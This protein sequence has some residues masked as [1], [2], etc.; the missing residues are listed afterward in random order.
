MKRIKKV[1]VY[2]SLIVLMLLL[3][4][5]FFVRT[6]KLSDVPM[7]GDEL[8][9]LLDAK[10]L[11]HTG[12]DQTGELLPVTFSMG[13]GRP[14][15]YVYATIP[16]VA[17]FGANE[18]GVRGLSLIS[19]I[20]LIGLLYL[21]GKKLF[22]PMVGLIAAGLMTFSFWDINLSRGGFEAHFALMLAVLGVLGILYAQKKP[23]WLII[24]AFCFGLTLHTYPTYKLVLPLFLTGLLILH[25][26]HVK[27]IFKR[28]KIHFLSSIMILAL[29]SVAALAQTF[30]G[31][32]ESRFLS[33]NI[34]SDPQINETIT[35]KIN[36]E[37]STTKLPSGIAAL[38]HNRPFEYVKVLG[39]NYVDNLSWEFLFLNGDRNPRHN[40]ATI[41]Y[42]YLIEVLTICLGFVAL[43]L[44]KHWKILG[45][46]L[47]WI[48]V[49]PL[50]TASISDPH[51]LRS[52]FMLP[53]LLLV[54]ALG[55]HLLMSFEKYRMLVLGVL[56]ISFIAQFI[57]FGEKLY[58]LAPS[59]FGRFWAEEGKNAAVLAFDN[60]HH[61]DFVIISDKIDSIEYSYPA[62]TSVDPREVIIQHPKSESFLES[63]PGFKK[64]DNV[65]IGN[66]SAEQIRRD[67]ESSQKSILYIGKNDE[68]E[69]F[70]NY[71]SIKGCDKNDQLIIA[72][73]NSK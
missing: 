16:F 34:F 36:Q 9:I 71:E 56:L 64:F 19:G 37:R 69:H 27:S 50:A 12:H 24:S 44:K 29:F 14:A 63:S 2:K 23:W 58:F 52:A 20:I 42:F 18:W 62:Y 49:A 70:A 4:V 53:G 6:Y 1:L 33:I 73:F 8:T 26:G 10:S 72:R 48:L 66:L 21:L 41:G 40:M 13:A 3:V 15:G 17:L 55:I 30:V 7:Y 60:K 28:S 67:A 39:N 51:G 59:S 57:Y 31:G 11:L 45:L 46:L 38:F 54:S 35:H 5:G 43:I 25:F 61:Y 65:Y 22:N 47:L 32:S 68:K